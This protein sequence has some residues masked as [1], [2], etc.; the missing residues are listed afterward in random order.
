[1]RSTRY[2]CQILIKLEISGQIFKK[3]I[4]RFQIT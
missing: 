1:M 3:K 4:V 2:F